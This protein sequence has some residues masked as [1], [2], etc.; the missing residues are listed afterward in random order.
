MYIQF[1][2]Y[3]IKEKNLLKY[4][5]E[6]PKYF[7]NKKTSYVY[8]KDIAKAIHLVLQSDIRNQILN[9]GNVQD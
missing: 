1:I 6:I 3:Q 8:V 5:I 4:D 9:I 2:H 7:M